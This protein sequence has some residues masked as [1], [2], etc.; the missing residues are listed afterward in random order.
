MIYLDNAATSYPKPPSVYRELVR[1]ITAPM[2]NPGRS[3]HRLSREAA[4]L[5]YQTREVLARLCG[6]KD[7][8]GIVLTSGATASLNMA[9][10]GICRG[11]HRRGI[12]PLAVTD[13]FEHNSVLRP[14]F[15]LEREGSL[16]LKILSP[17]EDGNLSAGH[18]LSLDPQM[19]I[20]TCRS[21]VTGHHFPLRETLETLRR[22]G[23]VV[24]ADGAQAVGSEPCSPEAFGADILCAPGHK[25]LMGIM[26]AGFLALRPDCPFLP[27]PLFSGGSGSA[28]FEEEMPPFL[29]DRLEA[30]TPP[31]AA[32]A[33]MGMGASFVLQKGI[34]TIAHG[35]REMKRLLAEGLSALPQYRMYEPE[36]Q[37]GPLLFNHR[38]LTPEAL[39]DALE[40]EGVLVRAGYHCAPLAHR[41]LGTEET[42]AVRLSPGAFTTRN[43]IQITLSVLGKL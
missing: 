26:G 10:H 15:A 20:L 36:Y 17:E 19:V 43:Q 37:A 13:V 32:I 40:K 24:I 29:P 5:I 16:R 27:E 9:I 31:L 21:N 42:G 22:R 12:L 28:S 33:A 7:P 25:G 35:E 30:G 38:R 39:A 11:F 34:E 8:T 4:G 14:L 2:G 1:H 18:L 3:G 6:V 41:Y 23:C